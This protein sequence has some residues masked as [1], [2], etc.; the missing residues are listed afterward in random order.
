MSDGIGVEGEVLGE[1]LE[2]EEGIGVVEQE[3]ERAEGQGYRDD[4]FKRRGFSTRSIVKD[5]DRERAY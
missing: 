5:D 2:C 4:R 3:A 1:V